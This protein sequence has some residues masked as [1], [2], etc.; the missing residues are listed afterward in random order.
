M[1]STTDSRSTHIAEAF[2]ALAGQTAWSRRQADLLAR[3]ADGP[4]AGL[5]ARRRHAIELTL[6]RL[7]GA[8]TNS[9][10]A[11]PI[12]AT[13]RRLLAIAA[14]IV[15][16]GKR[17]SPTGRACLKQ[18]V[19]TALSEDGTLVPLF[20][21]ARTGMLQAAR[22]FDVTHA[23]LESDVPYD[24]LLRRDGAEAEIACAVVSAEA[25]RGVQRAAWLRLADRIDPDL[26]TW[27]EAHPGRYL[28]KMTLPN[29]LRDEASTE[30]TLV[31]LHARIQTLLR[32]HL[33][34]DH[35]EAI[36][37]R[38]DPLLLAGA[39]AGDSGLIPSL[40][41]AFGPE[42][43]LSVTKAG[44]GVFAMAARAGQENDVP[45]AIR[46]HLTALAPT[47][48]TGDRPGI[49]SILVEDADRTEWLD[50][51]DR[52]RL[53]GETRHFLTCPEARGVIAV[54]FASRLEL[55]GAVPPDGVADGE[56]R[57]RNPGHPAAKSVA[58]APAVLSSI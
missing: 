53:E 27:L 47:R 33:R 5:A 13:E 26:Q 16:L 28:L 42:A 2:V 22:G 11:R 51:R 14:E 37:L 39:Q 58:L 23:G 29:G 46:R 32:T 20:H 7:R 19:R 38:L 43:H 4:R 49:L 54:S 52:L 17:L 1:A 45:A 35:D 44:G 56:L 34:Q 48:L 6:E 55:F 57:Y 40:R 36:V 30:D 9:P 8:P 41:D 15:A 18:R 25:G 12:A 10:P 21:L 50:P 3:A 24:L 31:A